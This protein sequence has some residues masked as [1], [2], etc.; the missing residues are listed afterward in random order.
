M[1]NGMNEALRNEE[2]KP[3]HR[4]TKGHPKGQSNPIANPSVVRHRKLSVLSHEIKNAWDFEVLPDSHIYINLFLNCQIHKSGAFG[5]LGIHIYCIV[6]I[7][8][9][10]GIWFYHY[11]GEKL[12]Q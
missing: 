12:W 2:I 8:T 5:Y 6:L 3:P 7:V 4:H 1:R 9:H 10:L 11:I